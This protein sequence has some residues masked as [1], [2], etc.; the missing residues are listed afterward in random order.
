[1]KVIGMFLIIW[2]HFFPKF[3][4]VIIYSFNVPL[5]FC[6]SGYLSGRGGK[7]VKLKSLL[8]PYL[9]ICATY[10]VIEIPWQFKSGDLNPLNY[11]RSIGYMLLGFQKTPNGVGA[12]AM[13]FVYTLALCKVVHYYL[14]KEI[15]RFFIALLCLSLAYATRD[16]HLFWSF[17]NVFICYPF[18]YVGAFIFVNGQSYIKGYSE[19]VRVKPLLYVLFLIGL[20]SLLICFAPYN[21]FVMM[22]QC[23]YGYYLW[24]FILLSFIGIFLIFH[25]SIKL[26][27]FKPTFLRIISQGNIVIL[28]YHYIGIRVFDSVCKR[29]NENLMN[30]DLLSFVVSL[31][32]LFLFVPII[33]CVSRYFPIIMGGRKI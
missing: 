9:V 19:L 11:L 24:L 1:M 6:I 16:V 10:L 27:T 7:K 17:Q 2:G 26:E 25:L 22:Y 5:F 33:K 15:V 12:S 4:N 28:A 32:V 8:I 21:G 14:K 18:Y 13:W 23:G 30:N 29:L 20:L 3:S 31:F